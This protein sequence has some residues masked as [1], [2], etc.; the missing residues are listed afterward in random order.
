MNYGPYMMPYSYM[1]MGGV[2]TAAR[3]GGILRGLFGGGLNFGSI[4]SGTGRVLNIANQAIPVIKQTTPILRNAKTMFKVMNE[5]KKP[6]T[7]ASNSSNNS[8]TNNATNS[9]NSTNSETKGV[10]NSTNPSYSVDGGPTF[11]M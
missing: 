7:P 11:F 5:F 10:Q 6:D 4:L 3:S 9:S 8:T 2:A 1:P